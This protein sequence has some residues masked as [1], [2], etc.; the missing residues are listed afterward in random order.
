MPIS[1]GRVFMYRVVK[2]V[3]NFADNSE[4]ARRPVGGD[5]LLSGKIT[6]W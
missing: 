6:L 3:Y 2:Q 5:I 1:S 4:A